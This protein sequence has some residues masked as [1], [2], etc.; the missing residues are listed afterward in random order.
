MTYYQATVVRYQSMTSD[1][2]EQ[3][4]AAHVEALVQLGWRWEGRGLVPTIGP[5]NDTNGP[6][7][8]ALSNLTVD[9]VH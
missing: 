4:V 8:N 5:S 6:R 1:Q 7:N 3:A 9:S 2:K